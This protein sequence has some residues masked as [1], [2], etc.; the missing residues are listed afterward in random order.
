MRAGA[1]ASGKGP[2]SYTYNSAGNAVAIKTG[3]SVAGHTW[4]LYVRGALLAL[5]SMVLILFKYGW[6]GSNYVYSFLPTSGTIT[7]FSG[8]LKAFFAVR[9]SHIL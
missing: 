5:L 4:N 9:C 6:N 3:I 7:S 8:D 2:I 1:D